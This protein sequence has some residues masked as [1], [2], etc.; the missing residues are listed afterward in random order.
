MGT[1]PHCPTCATYPQAYRLGYA[2]A[3][4]G[5]VEDVGHTSDVPA[6]PEGESQWW[7]AFYH[8]KHVGRMTRDL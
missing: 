3:I 5:W 4:E 6:D 1:S 2:E 7:L 8:G